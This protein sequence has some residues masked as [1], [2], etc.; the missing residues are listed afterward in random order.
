MAKIPEIKQDETLLDIDKAL[1]QEQQL[2]KPRHYLG[3]SQ[4]GEPCHRKLFYS[5]RGCEK[6][7]I[8]ASGIRAIQDGFAQEDIMAKRLKM[9]S[10]I[11]L[12]TEDPANPNK[13]IGFML[14]LDHFRGH[15]DGMIKGIKQAPK[16]WHVWE[17]KAVNETKFKK[18]QKL[19]D[20]K[21]EKKAL[22]E[23]DEIYHAQA[24][25]Y[26]HCS[27][28]ERHY[29]NVQTPGGRGY[30][31]CRT[32]YNKQFAENIIEKAKSIIFD[33]WVVPAK[34]SDK[35]E[36][37]LCKWCEFSE[38]CHDGK[39]PL[40]NCKTCRYSKPIEHGQRQCLKKDIIIDENLMFLDNCEDH[41]Y[42]PAVIPAKLIEQQAD[43]CIY[44][45]EIGFKFANTT[46]LGFPDVKDN[47]DGIYSSKDLFNDIKNVNNLSK[48]IAKV[49]D[50]FNGNMEP[51]AVRK[52][53]KQLDERLKDI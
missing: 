33:N 27:Q 37:Y 31:S 3:M 53:D 26:M 6:R 28:T 15:A 2:E 36:F 22:I 20:E 17:N 49:Q 13:Q 44:E 25:I 38:I 39:I 47:L 7:T 30:L 40:I 24:Q 29:L 45:T 14:L 52:W 48:G 34:L 18:L 42:N 8:Q 5:F 19:I 11:E 46:L 1:E 10:Y 51:S 16:T 12:H 41:I 32:E 43:G 21:G 50:I 35:R 23:W 9:L 4:I